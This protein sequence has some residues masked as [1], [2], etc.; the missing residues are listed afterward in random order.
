MVIGNA[1]GDS[2]SLRACLNDNRNNAGLHQPLTQNK[3][4]EK[5]RSFP[6]MSFCVFAQSSSAVTSRDIIYLQTHAP[7]CFRPQFLA[8]KENPRASMTL[9]RG[10]RTLE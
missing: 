1:R 9:E 2:D 4:F 3:I 6:E 7:R 8:P 10:R 5:V